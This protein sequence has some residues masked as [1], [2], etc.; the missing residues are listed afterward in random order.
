MKTFVYKGYDANGKTCRGQVEAAS[1]K[2]ARELLAARQVFITNLQVS[3]SRPSSLSAARRAIFY[4]ELAALLQAGVPLVTALGMLLNTPELEGAAEV[5]AAVRDQVREGV[6]LAAAL[7]SGVAELSSFEAATIDVAERAASL[8]AVLEQ[9]ARFLDAQQQLRERITRALIYP[10]LVLVL[11]VL[12]SIVMLGVLLPRTQQIVGSAATLPGLTRVMLGLGDLLVPWG[13]LAGLGAI[14]LLAGGG[15]RL[16][17]DPERRI[18]LDRRSYGIPLVGRGYRSLVA[19]RFARTLAILVRSGVSLVEGVA[20]AGR[21]TGST[22]CERLA[23]EASGRIRHGQSLESAVRQMPPLAD[24]L[25]GWLAV[26]E[27][28]GDLPRL[29]DHAADRCDV[30]FETTLS[31]GLTLLEPLL[32]LIVGAFVLLITLAVM[33]PVFSLSDAILR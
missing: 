17:A 12:V 14:L 10:G 21:A 11:G 23:V 25:P 16:L 28:G 2:A 19:A 24:S 7:K 29:L 9:L 30:R 32:L 26:G 13:L 1:P 8:E 5:L 6:S 4:R 18:G 15:R 20:L 3:G 31:R 22:W 33:L 27:A